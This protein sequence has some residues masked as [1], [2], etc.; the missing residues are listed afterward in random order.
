MENIMEHK[1]TKKGKKPNMSYQAKERRRR[2]ITRL[3]KYLASNKY[4]GYN[5]EAG[6]LT[7]KDIARIKKEIEVLKTRI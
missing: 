6:E 5:H 2:V 7:E 3:E 4:W 1:T